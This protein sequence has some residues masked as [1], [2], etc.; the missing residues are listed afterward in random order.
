[1]PEAHAGELAELVSRENGKPVAEARLH[2][3]GFLVGIVRYFGSLAD[4]LPSESYDKGSIYTSTVL[5]ARGV[6]GEIIPFNWPAIHAGGK[7]AP[8]LAVGNTSC[9]SRENRPALARRSRSPG[10]SWR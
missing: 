7:I 6:V 9:S 2:D 8:A 3:V 4:N 1:V 10:I 5:E